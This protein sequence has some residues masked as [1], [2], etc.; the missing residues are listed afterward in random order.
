MAPLFT[1]GRH[2]ERHAEAKKRQRDV[3]KW[4]RPGV[5]GTFAK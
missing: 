3:T 1:E 4:I 5:L 2:A